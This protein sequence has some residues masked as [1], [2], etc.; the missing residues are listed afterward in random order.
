MSDIRVGTCGYSYYNPP[1]GWKERYESK[2]QAY[3]EAFEVGEINRTFYK[4]PM[5]KTA[6]RWRREAFDDFEFTLKAWQAITHPTS[7]PTW[8]GKRDKLTEGQEENFGYLRPKEEVLEAWERTREI[9]EALEARVCVLQTSAGFDCSEENESNMREFLARID[10]GNLEL[11]WEPRGDWKENPGRIKEVCDDLDLI[12][13][14]DLLRRE[15]V[16]E[17][18]FS[19]VR[20]HGLN[21]REYD[22]DYDYSDEELE[23]L[24]GKLEELAGSHDRVYCMF[25]NYEMYDN[26]RRLS[27]IIRGS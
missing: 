12:H 9:G 14:V 7:S 2:L 17:H 25:N 24:A 19:Y 8:R 22:Y 6:E 18:P 1:E 5:T 21:Q 13:G 4:L 3:S 16:S 23:K 15:P 26:S 10:R 20:L 11:A 27:E